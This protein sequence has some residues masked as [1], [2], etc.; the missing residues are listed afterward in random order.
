[1][2][3]SVSLGMSKDDL[4]PALVNPVVEGTLNVFK[5]STVAKVKHVV[6]TSSISYTIPN[7][8]QV[9]KFNYENLQ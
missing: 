2:Q 8:S 5:A 9:D 3:G 4:K 7:P 1:M 6:V